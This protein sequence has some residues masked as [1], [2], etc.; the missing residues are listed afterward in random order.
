LEITINPKKLSGKVMVPPSKSVSHRAIIC[1]SLAKGKSLVKNI[2]YSQDIE[3]T[4]DC[5]SAMGMTYERYEDSL[6]IN[7]IDVFNSNGI[8]SMNTRESGS[9]I[10]FLIPMALLCSETV[11]VTG[12]EKLMQRPLKPYF[13]IFDTKGIKYS[14][15]GNKLKLSG[16]LTSGTYEIAGDVSSQFIS[17][18]LFALPLV[19]GNSIVKITTALE[20]IGYVDLT[21]D[22]LKNFGIEIINNDYKE[23]IIKGN[24]SY[25]AMDCTVEGDYSQ[26]A[27]YEVAKVLGN[28]IQCLGLNENSSQGDKEILSIV[29]KV[30]NNGLNGIKIDVKDI[31]DLVPILT[32]LG[33]FC[34]GTTEIYNAAR[35]RIKESDRLESTTCELRKLGAK[36]TEL[37]DS[38]IIEGTGKLKGGVVD[39]WNDHR[40]AMALAIASTI[41]EEPVTITCAESV[42]KSY[43]HFWEHFKSIGGN[44]NE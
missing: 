34:K 43:P 6:T 23:F 5:M 19:E 33:T 31:P 42:N 36:I 24:Q 11:E 4:L 39:S 3:A 37:P 12:S 41:C 27:F 1:A 14:Y 9:T 35:V 44:I 13:D 8:L 18:L 38:L 17:G 32:V 15:E 30:K 25:K 40:I 28:D 26:A 16:K 29:E 2:K 20:S 21:L 7:G 22:M 10:R